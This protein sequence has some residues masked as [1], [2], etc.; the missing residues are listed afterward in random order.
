MKLRSSLKALKLR[1]VSNVVVKRRSKTFVINKMCS[2][3]K[4][5]QR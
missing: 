2:K 3:F 5:R 1:H 4:A